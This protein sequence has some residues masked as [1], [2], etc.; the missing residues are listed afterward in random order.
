MEF[1]HY[2]IRKRTKYPWCVDA[3][4]YQDGL[5]RFRGNQKNPSVVLKELLLPAC[6]YVAMPRDYLYVQILAKGLH[7]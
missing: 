3:V 6:A 5:K 7:P 4:I 1:V 2:D